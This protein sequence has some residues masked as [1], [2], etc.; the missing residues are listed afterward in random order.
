MKIIK[1]I[2]KVLLVIVIILVVL[3]G[4]LLGWLTAVEYK[5]ADIEDIRITSMNPQQDEPIEAD[6]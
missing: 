2:L 4:A 1:I 6:K 3:A 5:P